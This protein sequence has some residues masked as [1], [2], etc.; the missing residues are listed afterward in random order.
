MELSAVCHS[1]PE[2]LGGTLV[3]NG[4]RV[5]VR[6]LMDHLSAGESIEDFLEGFPSVRREQVLALLK[7]FAEQ[8]PLAA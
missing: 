5:P 8:L 4:T 7:A 1:D 6:S 2:T 3:F